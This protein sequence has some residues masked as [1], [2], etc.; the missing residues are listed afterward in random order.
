M[1]VD[2]I[3]QLCDHLKELNVLFICLGIQ[4]QSLCR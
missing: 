2:V 1:H 3:A 4:H